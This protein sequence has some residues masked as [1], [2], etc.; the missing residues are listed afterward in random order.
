[1]A[2]LKN[3]KLTLQTKVAVLGC[4]SCVGPLGR[5]TRNAHQP[6]AWAGSSLVGWAHNLASCNSCLHP[7]LGWAGLPTDRM[8]LEACLVGSFAAL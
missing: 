3:K 4:G 5:L 7:E 8:S 1:M 2:A 6:W